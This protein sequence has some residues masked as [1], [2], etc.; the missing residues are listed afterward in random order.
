MDFTLDVPADELAAA[1]DSWTWIGLGDKTPLFASLFGDVFLEDTQGCWYLSQV[2][3]TL[4]CAWPDRAALMAAL[5]TEAG[6]DEYLL[7]GLVIAARCAGVT[8]DPG[9][10]YDFVPPPIL[11]GAIGVESLQPM[12]FL[13]SVHIG[14][15]LHDQVRHLEPGTPITGLRF[16]DPP[17]S[18]RRRRFARRRRPSG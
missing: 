8:L 11:G 10:V 18:P 17:T 1:L 12:S 14:G 15:Q 9:Q 3:G 6:Q 16:E 2:E 5:E 7:A 13:V 4:T